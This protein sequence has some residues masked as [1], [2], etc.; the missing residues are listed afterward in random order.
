V[1][2][3]FHRDLAENAIQLNRYYAQIAELMLQNQAL[4][5]QL[6]TLYASLRPA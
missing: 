2:E 3:G 5:T 4:H 1:M 6:A